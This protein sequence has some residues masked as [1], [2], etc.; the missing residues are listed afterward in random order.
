MTGVQTCALPISRSIAITFDDGAVD[1][2]RRALPVLREFNAPATLYLTTYYSVHRIPVFDT[3]LSYV[4][5]KGRR[6]GVDVAACCE[7]SEPLPVKT[8]VERAR[9]GAQLKAFALSREL[10]ADA[11]HA[12]VGRIAA[13][14]GVNFEDILARELLHIMSPDTVR[15]L[16]RDLVDVQLHTHRHRTPRKREQFM[17]EISDN[18][19]VITELRGDTPVLE[20]FCYPSGTYFGEFLPWLRESGVHHATT[21]IP[22]LA[23][24]HADPLLLPRFVDTMG[25]SN[26]AFEAWA[27]GF[28]GLLPHR[29]EYQLDDARLGVAID[30]T[31]GMAP[32]KG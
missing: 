5:W 27:S 18:I 7:H 1:F 24:R 31:L 6:S 30:A 19:A 29:R 10:S 26:L 12:L 13:A 20:H 2:E 3:V 28:A 16:P 9:A 14:L 32:S 11:K 23:D 15:A 21:C 22:D 17:R 8:A 25:Q 4:L